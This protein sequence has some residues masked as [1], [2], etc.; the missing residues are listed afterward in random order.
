M[1]SKLDL[2][3]VSGFD[4]QINFTSFSKLGNTEKSD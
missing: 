3:K 4:F 1:S 2:H